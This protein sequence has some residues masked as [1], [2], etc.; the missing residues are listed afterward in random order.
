MNNKSKNI[1][2]LKNSSNQAALFR[3][4]T[5]IASALACF[6]LLP[7]IESK[8]QPDGDQGNGNTAEGNGALLSLTTGLQNTAD[9]LQSLFNNTAGNL[10]TAIGS[11]ALSFNTVGN[12]NSGIGLGALHNN[13]SGNN[14]TA[15]GMSALNAN[16]TGN[17]NIGVG[18]L[19][20]YNLT[21]GDFNIDIGNQGNAGEAN[22]I[23]I[24]D[25]NQSSTF[26][27]GINGVPVTGTPVVVDGNGQLGVLASSERFKD[28]IKPMDKA[29]EAVLGLKP[30]TFRYKEEVDPKQLPQFGL[31]AEEVEKVDPDL[32][33][34]DSNGKVYTVR[35]EAVNAMLLNEFLKQHRRVAELEETIA[36]LKSAV[37][38]QEMAIAR[39]QKDR[40]NPAAQARTKMSKVAPQFVEKR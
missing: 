28:E 35:Y 32:V 29:S 27:A 2:C 16:T 10:N 37:A 5:F 39:Q 8:Q 34:R 20:G 6:V 7:I 3:R 15:A 25:A 17:N 24:G 38:K 26:I 36:Q 30:V 9:G 4:L 13:I 23:R 33:A 21:T 14:N 22:T 19:A 31:V 11:Q 1:P 12:Q 18:Y 40:P